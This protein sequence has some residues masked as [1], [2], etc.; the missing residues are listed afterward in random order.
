MA[1]EEISKLSGLELR[2][3]LVKALHPNQSDTW[4]NAFMAAGN[5]DYLNNWN[6]LMPLVVKYSKDLDW[7]LGEDFY[8]FMC[9][10]KNTQRTLAECLL[11]VILNQKEPK[12]I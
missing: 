9:D 5:G 8:H 3:E 4:Y 12:Q 7:E 2:L 6:D 1:N 10:N 11:L